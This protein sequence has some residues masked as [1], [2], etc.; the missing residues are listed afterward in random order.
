M[1]G[2][3]TVQFTMNITDMVE[4]P[5]L[6]AFLEIVQDKKI[7]SGLDTYLIVMLNSR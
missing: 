1:D 7:M 4:N 5:T 3:F 2:K 6:T